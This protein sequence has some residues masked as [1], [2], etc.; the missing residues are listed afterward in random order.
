[1][2]SLIRRG[3]SLG[4]SG[5]LLTRS[6][7]ASLLLLTLLSGCFLEGL[8]NDE[9]GE[10]EDG[11]YPDPPYGPV[12]FETS[13]EPAL[14]LVRDGRD[15]NWAPVRRLT[16]T[17]YRAR[18]LQPYTVL[19]V[20]LPAGG[21][22]ITELRS[23]MPAY[24]S[25][26]ISIP[27]TEEAKP[28]VVSGTM[29]QPGSVSLGGERASSTQPGWSFALP[30]RAGTQD[31]I[32]VSAD[33]VLVQRGLQV[34]ADLTLP[35]LDPAQ[36]GAALVELS[37]GVSALPGETLS[38][39]TYVRTEHSPP[40]EVHR[41][42]PPKRSPP[43]PS[44]QTLV[45]FFA[46]RPIDGGIT[47]RTVELAYDPMF[48]SHIDVAWEPFA[49]LHRLSGPRG[50]VSWQPLGLQLPGTTQ[51]QVI[52]A[53][54]RRVNHVATG[55]YLDRAQQRSLS[56]GVDAPGYLPEWRI[57]PALPYDLS[58]ET[59]RRA[60]PAALTETYRIEQRIAPSTA[61]AS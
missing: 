17:S 28:F 56:T 40:V 27:C 53:G 37:V 31:L 33:R 43:S 4:S 14:V 29:A 42:L 57:D 22:A 46:D 21:G 44:E 59:T 23:E 41:G 58:F 12:I 1:M 61:P 51:L 2:Q 3:M 50:E 35:L 15:G 39:A 9:D 38:A 49:E 5:S 6:W 34:T 48:T 52:G 25:T 36:N 8:G 32:A 16:A 55:F 13:I 26:S 18:P 20:C 47:R 45:R 54:G 19:V 10:F 7:L 30:A 11:P 24:G 60:S